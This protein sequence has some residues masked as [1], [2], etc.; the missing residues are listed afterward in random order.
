MRMTEKKCDTIIHIFYN[1]SCDN[2]FQ[3]AALVAGLAECLSLTFLIKRSIT[4][5]SILLLFFVCHCVPSI[6]LE[7]LTIFK[8]LQIN[9]KDQYKHLIKFNRRLCLSLSF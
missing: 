9:H 1:V 7:N 3:N 5:G 8:Y 2:L 6:V 4:K